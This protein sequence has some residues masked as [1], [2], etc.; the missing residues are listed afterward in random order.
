MATVSLKQV[1]GHTL[2]AGMQL[3]E[4]QLVM[5]KP[6]GRSVRSLPPLTHW[7]H[8]KDSNATSESAS[9]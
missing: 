5:Q 8:D 9:S 6:V 1:R 7:V 2:D 4:K 3:S